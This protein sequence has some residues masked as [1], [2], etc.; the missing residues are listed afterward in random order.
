MRVSG[1]T[2][3]MVIAWGRQAAHHGRCR[4]CLA[5]GEDRHQTSLTFEGVVLLPARTLTETGV[6]SVLWVMAPMICERCKAMSMVAVEQ[7][8]VEPDEAAQPITIG[9]PDP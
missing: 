3:E 2:R 9:S 8:E 6:R 1:I 4:F 5:P 7:V